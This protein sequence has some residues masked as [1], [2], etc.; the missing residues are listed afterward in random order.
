LE[1][2]RE[3]LEY[4]NL[5]TEKIKKKEIALSSLETINK[6]VFKNLITITKRI[7]KGKEEYPVKT[8]KNEEKELWKTKLQNTDDVETILERINTTG[9]NLM[10]NTSYD[11]KRKYERT[12]N[13]G[14]KKKKKSCPIILVPAAS[15]ASLSIYNI[16][17]FLE[18]N[19]YI[20]TDQAKKKYENNYPYVKIMRNNK[21]YHCYQET[22]HFESD[23]WKNIAAIFTNGQNWQ[24]K[25]WWTSN[26]TEIFSKCKHFYINFF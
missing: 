18:N 7:K 19:V 17:E 26:P 8:T 25:D 14:E 11:K 6:G 15:T 4:N 9:S 12:S 13:G 24:F 16:K 23:D 3:Y 2:Y 20:P 10:E 22:K 1:K 21:E 5:L